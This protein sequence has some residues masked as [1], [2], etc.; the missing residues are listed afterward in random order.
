[1]CQDLLPLSV[2]ARNADMFMD[3]CLISLLFSQVFRNGVHV[4][5]K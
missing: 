1:M 4:S 5:E 2:L 3:F